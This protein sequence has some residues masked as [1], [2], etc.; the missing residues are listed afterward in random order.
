MVIS[1]YFYHVWTTEPWVHEAG[2][3]DAKDWTRP[4][5]LGWTYHD[6]LNSLDQ[7]EG[8]AIE[9]SEQRL[10]LPEDA[11]SPAHVAKAWCVDG[12]NVHVGATVLSAGR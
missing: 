9:I 10:E 5:W 1:G 2:R 6:I 8:L 7:E 12:A 11:G 3:M 4:E